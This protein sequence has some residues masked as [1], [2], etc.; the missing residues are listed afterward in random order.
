KPNPQTY[1]D[2]IF[3]PPGVPLDG[4]R[5][6]RNSRRIKEQT[7]MPDLTEQEKRDKR[8]ETARENGRKSKGP[9]TSKGKR[10]S[11]MNAMSHGL[12]ANQNTVLSAES[13]K[14]YDEV[15]KAY[16]EDLRPMT[17]TELSIVQRIAN[18]DW[19]LERAVMMETCVYNMNTAKHVDEILDRFI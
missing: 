5:I 1:R 6:L 18:L 10:R 13:A 16:I 14:Q 8:A 2:S 11:A 7:A 12:T 15:L 3:D 17:K 4:G 19:R 9:I